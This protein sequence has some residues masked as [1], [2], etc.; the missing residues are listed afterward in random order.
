MIHRHFPRFFVFAV[1]LAILATLVSTEAPAPAKRKKKDEGETGTGDEADS[2]SSNIIDTAMQSGQFGTFCMAVK[3]AGL[4]SSLESEGPYTVFAPTDEAFSELGEQLDELLADKDALKT[5][6]QGHLVLGTLAS[7]ALSSAAEPQTVAGTTL[8]I[9]K[10]G[11]ADVTVNG[12]RIVE[13]DLTATNG[14]IHGID[15]VF[16]PPEEKPKKRS[17]K[18]S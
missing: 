13:P 12:A 9:E 6:L 3:E 5:V 11:K 18:K 2:D 1:G 10:K 17:A 14:I 4:T 15:R 7:S 16:L 8:S